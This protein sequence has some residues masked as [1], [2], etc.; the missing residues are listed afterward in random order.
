MS[1]GAENGGRPSRAVGEYLSQAATLRSLADKTRYPDVRERLL[2]L[3]ASFER[4]AYE[5]EKWQD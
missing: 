2:L 5:V 1:A 3:A 4:L